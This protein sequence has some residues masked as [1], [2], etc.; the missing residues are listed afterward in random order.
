MSAPKQYFVEYTEE[1]L[2]NM[3]H[4]QATKGLVEK[5]QRFCEYYVGSHNAKTA[6]IKAGY[7]P[8]TAGRMAVLIKSNEQVRIYIAWLKVRILNKCM[9]KGE[10]LIDMWTRV[11]FAD[12]TDF[13]D[14]FPHS[15]R[16]K[17]SEQIDGQLVKS[18]KSGRDGVSIELY[19]KMKALDCLQKY[20]DCMPKD[21]KQ[22]LEERKLE[23]MEE[24]LILKKQLAGTLGDDEKDDGFIEAI[25]KAA[26]N[27]QW[28]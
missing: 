9:L 22:K 8:E 28:E 24:E 3:S 4:K 7:D 11:A 18:I 21:Y 12:M 20:A 15:I 6:A 13:V 5:R 10:E 1:E 27:V 14:I 25:A 17:P 16:L 23:I 19:D 2:L 26:N